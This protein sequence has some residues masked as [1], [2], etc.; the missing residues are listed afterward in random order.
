MVFSPSNVLERWDSLSVGR[1]EIQKPAGAL[2][3]Q[4]G[5]R[6]YSLLRRA[7]PLRPW[8]FVKSIDAKIILTGGKGLA[9]LMIEHNVGVTMVAAYETKRVDSDYV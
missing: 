1:P 6:G 2:M 4:R 3:G 5:K 9:D 8:T 7:S